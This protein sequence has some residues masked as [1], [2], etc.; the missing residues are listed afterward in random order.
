VGGATRIAIIP[1]VMSIVFV[2]DDD[3]SVR[4]SLELLVS[5]AGWQPEIFAS[6]SEF[7][8]RPRATVPCCFCSTS[9]FQGSPVS[10]CSSS[11]PSGPRCR[12]S[13][14]PARPGSG[15]ARDEGWLASCSGD[16]GRAPRPAVC[17]ERLTI[18]R[19][20]CSRLQVLSPAP[21]GTWSAFGQKLESEFLSAVTSS[22]GGHLQGQP[23][24]RWAHTREA[25]T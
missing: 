24:P 19:P 11:S 3:V 1:N 21:R 7:L 10:S 4:E 25:T 13:S 22:P 15:H 6:A 23:G 18:G 17:A 20:V 2:V 16:N 14:S 5:T 9:R 12:S 8:S